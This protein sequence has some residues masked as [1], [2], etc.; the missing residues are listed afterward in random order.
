MFRAFLLVASVAFSNGAS[1]IELGQLDNFENSDDFG[2][3]LNRAGRPDDPMN[4]RVDADCGESGDGDDCLSIFTLGSG[5]SLPGS[6]LAVLNKEQWAGDYIA[7]GVGGIAVRV[8]NTSPT[9]LTVELRVAVQGSN[10]F[11]CLLKDRI[12]APR[13]GGYI[14]GVI[15]VGPSFCEASTGATPAQ[16]D[17]LFRSVT[18]I[19]I[20]HNTG[21][22]WPPPAVRSASMEIDDI[23]AMDD[24]VFAADFEQ[25]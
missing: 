10:G 13:F 3:Q 14:D 23:M 12:I 16:L 19:W 8:R 15:R 1:A 7:A 5:S 25:L 9:N 6:R 2:W 17:Q 24:R 18:Q 4:V 22:R 11:R 20:G 21:D